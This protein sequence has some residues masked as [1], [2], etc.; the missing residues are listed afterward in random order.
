MI[1]AELG[2][3]VQ[4]YHSVTSSYIYW[5]LLDSILS[6]FKL[7]GSKFVELQGKNWYPLPL[8]CLKV[9]ITIILD[10]LVPSRRRFKYNVRNEKAMDT[11]SRISKIRNHERE[12]LRGPP[13]LKTVQGALLTC[14]YAVLDYAQTGLIAAVFIFK[15]STHTL[16]RL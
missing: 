4:D 12:R 3:A 15:V 8:F 11:S 13:W 6:A 9:F 5:T 10:W 2:F 16:H 14:S 1:W 7:L